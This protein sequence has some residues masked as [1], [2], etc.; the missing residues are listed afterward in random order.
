MEAVR[1]VV[2]GCSQAGRRAFGPRARPGG[3]GIV[4]MC[5][6][7]R[8][9]RRRAFTLIELLVVIAIIAVL[10]A[11]LL[12]AVQAAREAAR[13]I[14]CT[15]NLKQLGLGVHNYVSTNGVL[16][17]QQVLM[18]A[19]T[20]V[21]WK[22]QW[23][24]TSRLLP[25]AEQ[26]ALFNAIN[27]TLKTSDPTNSTV[28]SASVNVLICPSEVNSQP[29]TSTNAKTGVVSVYGISNYGWCEGDWYVFGG[30]TAPP[31]RSAF[32]PNLSR[33]LA[34][35]T[36]GLSQT[37]LGADVKANLPAYHDCP[38]SVPASLASPTAV[39]TPS[40]VMA[41]VAGAAS[42]GC[43]V[44]SGHNHWCNGNTF[45]DGL[46]TALPPNTRSNAGTPAADSDLVSEDEDDGGPT[47]SSVTARSYHPGGVNALFGDGSVRFVKNSIQW[48]TWRALGSIG[49]GEVISA[50][51]Y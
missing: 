34:A 35:F 9:P 16:P 11:L 50:D 33:T 38:S 25:Y 29:T 41:A 17:P 5:P 37:V 49:G 4:T 47:Y 7:E 30:N 48:Q 6:A 21:S 12:P 42:A 46:T 20:T 26:G 15:N 40:A 45:Y 27:F 18:Y 8:K 22:S 3:G 51:A 13:R 36:D 24:V 32:G 23:G 10:I 31:N 19:G 1:I 2:R 44:A 43:R 39:P 28:V 14:Q